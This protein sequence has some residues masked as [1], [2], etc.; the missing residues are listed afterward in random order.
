MADNKRKQQGNEM[1]QEEQRNAPGSDRTSSGNQQTSQS[2][3]RQGIQDARQP[4]QRN[5]DDE[6]E[7]P[8]R[9]R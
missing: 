1:N 7:N 5:Q 8:D 2:G 9:R 4:G 3:N 6:N